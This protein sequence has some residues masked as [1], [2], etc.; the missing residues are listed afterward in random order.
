VYLAGV[1]IGNRPLVFQRGIRRFH[2]ALA[3]LAQ[4]VMFVTLGLLCFPSRLWEVSGKALLICLVLILV[5]RP[6]AVWISAAAFRFT[7]RELAFLSWV[8][9]KGAVPITLATFP[10]M[11][12][13]PEIS[14]QA[15]L[16]FDVVFFIVVVSA[17]VQGTS[18]TLVARGLGLER[19]REP[20]PPVTLEISSLRQVD[21][22]VV[23]YTVG[24]DSRAAGRQ[25]RD[26]A[27]PGG[28]VI[29]LIARGDRIIPP[30]GITRIHAGDHVIVVLRRGTQPLVDRVFGRSRSERSV[31]P[32]A[33]EFPFRGTTTVG[34]LQ[35][36]Y[37]IRLEASPETT[38][39]EVMRRALGSD[40]TALGAMV[41]LGALRFRILRLG[42]AGA[43]E[44][45]GMSVLPEP[46]SAVGG[47]E[48][49]GL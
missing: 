25:V 33:V 26:L 6:V 1:V 41:E 43:V 49:P 40:R 36:F 3:W 4:I 7:T 27:L 24:E 8:G 11:L 47:A 18:L 10:L 5:A 37:S 39:D 44:L 35:D 14:M 30:Q 9:L 15:P 23:D 32:T 38:L 13:T 20:E 16:V 29:A 42:E 2:D 19:P 46:E 34:E 31:V 22:E 17:A 48:R 45:V 21:G 28:V 12:A